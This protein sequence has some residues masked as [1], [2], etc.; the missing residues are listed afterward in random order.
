ME[1]FTSVDVCSGAGGLALGLERAGFDPVLVLDRHQDACNTLRHNRPRWKT[2]QAD[3]LNFDPVEHPEAYD[4]DLLSADLPRVRSQATQSRRETGEELALIRATLYLTHAVQPRVLLIDNVPQLVNHPAYE[5]IREFIGKELIHLGYGIHYLVLNAVD[6]GVPQV[7]PHGF[8]VAFKDAAAARRFE[9]PKPTVAQHN[10]VGEVLLKSM[11]TRGWS[12]AAG[13]A[14]KADRPGPTLVGGSDKRGG[15]DLGP[16]RS[17]KIWA[18]MGINGKSLADVVPGPDGGQGKDP[19][20]ELK[21][22]TVDQAATLQG[23][24]SDWVIT[25]RKTVRYR[26]VGH[27]TPPPVGEALGKAIAS[28]LRG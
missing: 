27:A 5:D 11:I 20:G 12:G 1:R 23:F 3:L 21:K 4:V 17:K 8:V 15:A 22:I 14:R 19:I 16:S 28:A 13:W 18:T 9:V 6:F 2:L 25:G 26:Q 10:T 7:R 24:P